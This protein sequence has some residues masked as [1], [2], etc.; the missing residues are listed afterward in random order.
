MAVNDQNYTLR[1]NIDFILTIIL[2]E[3]SYICP[4]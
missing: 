3:N 2:L 1:I 4:K